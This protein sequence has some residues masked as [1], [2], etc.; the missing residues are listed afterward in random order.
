ML[1]DLGRKIG[2]V[3]YL[4]VP[5]EEVLDRVA[6]R[7]TCPLCGATYHL[8][9]SPPKVPGTCDVCG[10]ELYQ[11]TDDRRDVVQ[12]RL[13]VYEGQTAPVIDLY[14]SR[15]ILAEVDGAQSI[16]RVFEAE[17]EALSDLGLAPLIRKK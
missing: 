1:A 2:A 8:R 9:A 15:G 3:V 13:E 6:S 17:L 12:R 14:R 4:R 11:R 10:G 16:E 5:V 7:Y